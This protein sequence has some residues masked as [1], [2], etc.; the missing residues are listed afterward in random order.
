MSAAAS[1]AVSIRMGVWLRL[2][3]S[4]RATEMP[5]MPGSMTSSTITSNGEERA[6]SK[7]S[8]PSCATTT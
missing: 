8:R 1:R 4:L 3:R 7:P 2:S 5:S 6:I